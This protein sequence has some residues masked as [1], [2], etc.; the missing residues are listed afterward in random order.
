MTTNGT[1]QHDVFL[2]YS[3]TESWPRFVNRHFM[4]KLR[5]WLSVELGRKVEV[6]QDTRKIQTGQFFDQELARGLAG[7]RIM[8]A[9]WSRNYFHSEWCRRE[10]AALLA[11]MDRFRGEGLADHLVFPLVLHDCETKEDVPE[12][13]GTMQRTPLGK[14]AEPFMCSGSRLDQALSRLVRKVCEQAGP[15]IG[16]VPDSSYRWPLDDYSA[17]LDK[18]IPS[19]HKELGQPPSLGS[20]P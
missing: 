4:P 7:S 18:L 15:A 17:Y 8:I 1:Y 20:T 10:L 16:A 9:L 6:F 19:R 2:S 3:R 11:R 12:V 14:L 13:V 5:H